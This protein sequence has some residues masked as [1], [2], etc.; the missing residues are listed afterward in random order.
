ME[1]AIRPPSDHYQILATS[2]RIDE[3]TRVLKHADAFAIFDR[4][5]DVVPFGLGE[6]GIYH[7]GTRHLS[8]FELRL[9]GTRPLLL[10][11][12][13]R[14]SND[15][16]V[17]DATN[18]DMTREGYPLPRDVLHVFRA[19]FLWESVCYERLRVTN[20]G[21]ETLQVSLA[22]GFGA[23][24]ADIFEVRGT[25]RPRRG[26]LLAPR[27][28]A[29]SLVL[30]YEGLDGVARQTT[31]EC[32]PVPDVIDGE[33]V[34]FRLTLPPQ[35]PHTIHVTIACETSRSPAAVRPYDEAFEASR[36][37][38]VA[39]GEPR[40]R[41]HTANEQFNDWIG[42]STADLQMMLTTTPYGVYPYAGVPWFNTPFGRD[43][44][45]TALE[46]LWLDPT[47]ARGVLAY[48]AATQ[49]TEENAF[50]DAEPGKI[51]HET[52]EGEMAALGEIPF[53]RY[54][55]SVDA[56]PLFVVLAGAYYERTADR[57][58]IES[59]WSNIEAAIAW[60]D[61]SG[62]RDG[63]GLIEYMRHTPEGLVQMRGRTLR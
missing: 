6:Q 42:R 32:A 21:L 40:P 28:T 17:V 38:F 14:E 43:G 13:V 26:R 37:S 12:L 34:V 51:L 15:L 58:F 20:H 57:R 5:G 31:V 44:I 63:D 46:V 18:P 22:L 56:T 54:Y 23:D 59:I 53:G 3:R 29:R 24:F 25:V 60:M 9:N 52:R 8:R 19:K 33:H 10:S 30:G 36:R 11:S 41:I 48:L 2:S 16:F 4:F 47:I 1:E 35:V 45:I 7:G 39:G 55:G 27:R 49:A 50:Q 62:D 61:T